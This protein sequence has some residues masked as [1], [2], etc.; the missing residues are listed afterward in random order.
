MK[1]TIP[2]VSQKMQSILCQTAN[3]VAEESGLIK[4][5]RK[6]NGAN[7]AQTLVLGWWSNPAATLEELCQTGGAVGLEI[8]AQGL[9]QRF[10]Q[11]TCLFLQRMLEE[12]VAATFFTEPVAVPLLRRFNGV[13]V[14]DS[15]IVPLP[16]ELKGC[17]LGSGGAATTS[18]AALKLQ[19]RLEMSQGKLEGP[20][21]CPGRV[22]D[23]AAGALHES[24][25]ASALHLADLGYWKLAGLAELSR[26][27][28]YWLTR[29][30]VQTKIYDAAGKG[31]SQAD[32]LKAQQ[33]D[34]LEMSVHL[35]A[36][37]QLPARLL[38]VRVPATVSAE[39]RRRIKEQA[40]RRGQKI[41]RDRL[42]LADW[43]LLVT[44]V[45]ATMLPL[46]E[47][48]ILTRL[49]WQIELLFKLWKSKGQIATWRTH[50]PWRILCEIYAKLI[51]MV[52]QHWLF[53][54]GNWSLH[55][56]S[57]I[58]AAKTVRQ[59][60]IALGVAIPSHKQLTR[61]IR[62]LTKCLAHGCRINKSRVTPRQ[63]QLLMEPPPGG[64][65]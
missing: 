62:R 26:Q 30:Q 13:Y 28:C 17:W 12:T 57:W 48:L 47:A 63:H 38:A 52:F 8:S 7:L 6:V 54:L 22:H 27:G 39:R 53:L 20:L 32:F 59:H 41:S 3:E 50:N 36:T 25:P 44:N 56:R 34:R 18:R 33:S 42:E 10:T 51:A 4:R 14:T 29:L 43:T 9:D 45:P 40:R 46:D 1:A 55:N 61:A 16:D 19:V 24:L 2:H 65:A 49:R 58:K 37:Y 23:R 21:L 11:E 35:G 31:W 5:Q 60:A 64:F 15:C